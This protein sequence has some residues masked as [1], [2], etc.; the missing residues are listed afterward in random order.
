MCALLN[1][2]NNRSETADRLFIV[3]CSWGLAAIGAFLLLIFLVTVFYYSEKHDFF[4][5]FG[6][7]V[8]GFL[9][10]GA[11]SMS[12]HALV[13]V[14]QFT[15]NKISLIEFIATQLMVIFFPYHYLR[16]KK[17]VSEYKKSIAE[18]NDMDKPQNRISSDS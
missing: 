10:I 9:W 16:L 3:F 1:N 7:L 17:E 8:S 15:E 13:R 4:S 2:L 12:R 14:K 5:L 11:T 18:P 6:I